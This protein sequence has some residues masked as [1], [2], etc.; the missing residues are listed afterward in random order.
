MPVVFYPP[1]MP[2]HD[3][4]VY[5][6]RELEDF[7]ASPIPYIP[8]AILATLLFIAGIW[9]VTAARNHLLPASIDPQTAAIV[10][11]L[12]PPVILIC[13]I[14][15]IPHLSS[16]MW[17][18]QVALLHDPSNKQLRWNMAVV[19]TAHI[20]CGHS[21]QAEWLTLMMGLTTEDRLRALSYVKGVRSR[22]QQIPVLGWRDVILSLG[23]ALLVLIVTMFAFPNPQYHQLEP[24]LNAIVLLFLLQLFM[25]YLFLQRW[26]HIRRLMELEE[27]FEELLPSKKGSEE[28]VEDEVER[29]YREQNERW[30]AATTQPS[31]VE[32]PPAPWE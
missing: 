24:F 31:S 20:Y 28:P 2:L 5:H 29:W 17:P 25:F 11:S 6:R 16:P 19:A 21:A 13:V 7:W 30:T 23:A 22:L 9:G 10:I 18:Y 14:L 32:Y 1:N 27:V 26:Q 12:L 8:F 15:I 3:R 4:Y